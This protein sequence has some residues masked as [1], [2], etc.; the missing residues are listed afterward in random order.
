M[1]AVL[2]VASNLMREVARKRAAIAFFILLPVIALA[3][4]LAM[5]GGG[6]LRS[7]LQTAVTYGAGLPVFLASLA[8]VF[9]S[10]GAISLDLESRRL[11][12]VATKPVKRH[13]ILAGKL[14]GVLGVDI[15]L[16]AI[17]FAA[18]TASIG[19]LARADAS[20]EERR[21]A[22]ER[23]FAVRRSV[24]ASPASLD[25]GKVR[26]RI[27]EL[28]ALDRPGLRSAE[29][30]EAAARRSL[31]VL[32]IPPG[33][34]GAIRFEGVEEGPPGGRI[35]IR[36]SLL[37]SPPGEAARIPCVWVAKT[38]AGDLLRITP[39]PR[40]PGVP[41]EIA[42]P[43]DLVDG[44]VLRLSLGTPASSGLTILADP[45][46][47]EALAVHG[48][49][50]GNAALA[51]VAVLGRLVL[52]AAIGLLAGSLLGFPTAC[53]LTGFIY[54]AGLAASFLRETFEEL[55]PGPEAASL[56]DR[57][58]RAASG[59]GSAVLDVLPDFAGL[60]PLGRMAEGRAILPLELLG[61]LG[62]TVALQGTAV[63]AV[64]ALILGLRE[65]D[66]SGSA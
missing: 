24:P 31:S 1:T 46:R 42:V 34:A 15:A 26:R 61:G 36:Y 39:P 57:I 53:L 35:F 23:F 48:G 9:L 17:T 21:E 2:A 16:L 44:G 5:D 19:I 51:F 8:T 59:I 40:S 12:T 45:E 54:C 14:L 47:M 65:I 66:R 4:P 43:G 37:A 28:E 38:K 22:S 32:T 11:A 33:T 52:L 60:D 62:W 49:V 10:A 25:P 6:T 7:R 55:A 30:I 29:E 50:W 64:A 20:P 13:A 18:L 58:E 56:L 63:F 41:H 3:L 27:E